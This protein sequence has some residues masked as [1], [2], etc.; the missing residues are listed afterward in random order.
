MTLQCYCGLEVKIVEHHDNY[1][2]TYAC[3]PK[4]DEIACAYF[5]EVDAPYPQKVMEVIDNLV[6]E[7]RELRDALIDEQNTHYWMHEEDMVADAAIMDIVG[8]LQNMVAVAASVIVV[9]TATV[10][11]VW[12][13]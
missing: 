8:R 3:C 12:L 4:R 2:R 7:N 9:L 1:R 10:A 13:R 6:A 11:S 5:H